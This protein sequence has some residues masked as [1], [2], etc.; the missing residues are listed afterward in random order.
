MTDRAKFRYSAHDGVLEIEGTEA[1][2]SKHFE[3]LTD[4]VRIMARHTIVEQKSDAAVGDNIPT[5]SVTPNSESNDQPA[6]LSTKETIESYP[7][8]YSEINGKLKL[9]V[10]IPGDATRTKQTNA[11]LLYCYGAA[12]MGDEQVTSKDIRE[13]CEEH[14]CIDTNFAKIFEDKTIFLSDGVK[15]GTKH[16]KLTFQGKKKAK[17]LLDA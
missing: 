13:V 4:I 9:T 12:L 5:A 8:V 6:A 17:E 15:G 10:D 3:G 14:G 11:A 16:I 1:F 2:V 7:E